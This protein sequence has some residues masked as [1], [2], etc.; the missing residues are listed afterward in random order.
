MSG[1]VSPVIVPDGEESP[2]VPPKDKAPAPSVFTEADYISHKHA[3]YFVPPDRFKIEPLPQCHA[4]KTNFHN[5]VSLLQC[6]SCHKYEHK[7]LRCDQAGKG[8]MPV[9]RD[10][11]PMRRNVNGGTNDS[12]VSPSSAAS[13]NGFGKSSSFSCPPVPLLP[14]TEFHI[15]FLCAACE[16]DEELKASSSP[17]YASRA[18]LRSMLTEEQEEHL[19]TLRYN[20]YLKTQAVLNTCF[21]R[22]GQHHQVKLSDPQFWRRA[23]QSVEAIARYSERSEEEAMSA[24]VSSAP[25]D[26]GQSDQDTK[27][28]QPSVSTAN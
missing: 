11:M 10:K 23:L 12:I 13:P 20:E 25:G 19:T 2:L 16:Q 15:E 5:D 18:E 8:E 21:Y 3:S 4:C 26:C 24:T 17:N 28:T 9:E 22:G 27:S 14:R 6:E 1:T 7:G